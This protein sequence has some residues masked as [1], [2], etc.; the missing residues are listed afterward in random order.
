LTMEW[1]MLSKFTGNETY[2]NLALGSVDAIIESKAYFPNM[3]ATR[4]WPGT[5]TA[6]AEYITVGGGF[7]SY[8]EYLVKLPFLIGDS[9]HR[10]VKAYTGMIETIQ[11]KL[12]AKTGVKK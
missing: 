11:K 6:S 12:V 3:P 7:D 1:T 5:E 4:I 2:S 8:M 10:F 9:G